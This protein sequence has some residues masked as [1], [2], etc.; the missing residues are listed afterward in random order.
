[1]SRTITP[2]LL[3]LLALGGC[4]DAGAP[5][6]GE[7]ATAPSSANAPQPEAISFGDRQL[8]QLLDDRPD[9]QEVIPDEHYVRNWVVEGFDGKRLG[10]R[11]YWCANSPQ[12]GRA[13]E[14]S[15][16]YEGYPA[17]IFISGGTETTPLDK[18]AALVYEFH[19]VELTSEWQQLGQKAISGVMSPEEYAEECVAIEYRALVATADFFEKHPLPTSAP[20]HHEWYNWLT[21]DELPTLE[22]QLA[23]YRDGTF[24]THP[25]NYHY[26]RSYYLE[27][28]APYFAQAAQSDNAQQQLDTSEAKDLEAE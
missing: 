19:N 8:A 12:S 22:E 26:F 17:F 11:I 13:A 5:G 4:H 7:D 3:L 15:P 21:T 23:P 10:T 24:A 25:T 18:W 6:G 28:I 20:G 27:S 16:P 14:H 2:V 9:M 1:M